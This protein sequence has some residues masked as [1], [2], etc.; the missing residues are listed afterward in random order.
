MICASRSSPT[1]TPD[2]GSSRAVWVKLSSSFSSTGGRPSDLAEARDIVGLWQ[3]DGRDIPALDLVRLRSRALLAAAEGD[4]EA[5]ARLAG[6]YLDL[7]EKLDARGRL[8]EARRMV[9]ETV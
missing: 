2:S 3:H 7:C 8:S 1:P 5:H 4:S 9:E 6:Q